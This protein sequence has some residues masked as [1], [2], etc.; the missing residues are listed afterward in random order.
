M[1]L[2]HLPCLSSVRLGEDG[3]VD[4]TLLLQHIVDSSDF[5]IVLSVYNK[6]G[7]HIIPFERYTETLRILSQIFTE[8]NSGRSICPA[9][10]DIQLKDCDTVGAIAVRD[11]QRG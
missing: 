11:K 8:R 5:H 10:L 2:I 3:S 6:F 9:S 4:Q 1:S 7:R